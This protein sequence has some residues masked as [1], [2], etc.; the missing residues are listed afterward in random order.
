MVLGE[1]RSHLLEIEHKI[2]FIIDKVHHR[3]SSPS[4]KLSSAKILS[5]TFIEHHTVARLFRFIFFRLFGQCGTEDGIY[6]YLVHGMIDLR[7][8]GLPCLLQLREGPPNDT[9]CVAM[10]MGMG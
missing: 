2:D 9:E 6:A 4:I 5:A 1:H 3:Q 7:E 8:K 10:G